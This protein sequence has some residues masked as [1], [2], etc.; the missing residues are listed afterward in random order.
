MADGVNLAGN[1]QALDVSLP[2]IIS[3]FKLL[4]DVT[5]VFRSTAEMNTLE[6]HTG[7]SWLRNN[8]GRAIAFNLDE[9]ADMNQAQTLAD[10]QTVITPSEVGAQI[11]LPGSTLRRV[12]DAQLESR[13]ATILNNAYNLKEDQDGA[14][15]MSSWTT[16]LGTTST[17]IGVGH[18]FAGAAQIGVGN[19][20]SAPEPAPDPWFYVGHD[21]QLQHLAGRLMVLTDVP[22]GT[23]IYTGTAA[24]ATFAAGH[25]GD[26]GSMEDEVRREGIGKLTR[27]ANVTIKKDAN[28]PVT[29]TPS[30]TGGLYSRAGF[31]YVS[32][33]E[34]HIVKQTDDVSLRDAV[35]LNVWGSYAFGLYRP[36]SYGKGMVF[37][38]TT[39]T[40]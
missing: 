3:D 17:I 11:V 12:Q 29:S 34:P 24:G 1:G 4:R 14:A 37:D 26:P 32:E 35:E 30:A 5:G 7:T 38:C 28:I 8:Y 2:T 10:Q 39:P 22:T 25:D 23:N 13:V 31:I 18:I 15:Q 16:S 19:S 36:G 20:V 40:A 6:R 21:F 27:M 33:V 9:A